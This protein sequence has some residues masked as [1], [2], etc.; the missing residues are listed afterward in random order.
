MARR[1]FEFDATDADGATHKYVC[2]FHPF[3][4]DA[5]ALAWKLLELASEPLSKLI[6]SFFSKGRAAK[7]KMSF[8]DID[9]SKIDMMSVIRDIGKLIGAADMRALTL[10]LLKY[11]WRDGQRLDNANN[12][13][14]AFSGNMQEVYPVLFNVIKSNNFFPSLGTPKS[15]PSI[16]KHN[17]P[18]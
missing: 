14:E 12:R 3:E 4:S 11:A 17:T 9:L 6:P 13:D 5:N 7:G 15:L 10:E 2:E 1:G 8:D 16:Q 18:K